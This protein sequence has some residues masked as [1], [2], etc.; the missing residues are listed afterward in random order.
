M[1]K[2]G[3]STPLHVR[4]SPLLNRGERQK[5]LWSLH[6]LILLRKRKAKGA[7]NFGCLVSTKFFSFTEITTFVYLTFEL[8]QTHVLPKERDLHILLFE[9]GILSS[10][11][12]C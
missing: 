6:R 9:L 10:P 1:R 5:R 3:I 11:H 4:L 7:S 12:P 2:I 8:P